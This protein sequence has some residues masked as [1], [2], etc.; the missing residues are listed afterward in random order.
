MNNKEIIDKYYAAANAGDWQTWLTL[1][2]DNVVV[3]EQ[4]AGHV[5]GI[6][7]LQGAIGGIERGYSKFINTPQH[8]VID[9]DT[10]CVVSHISAANASGVPIEA[11]VANYFE[12]KNG[13]ITYMANFHDTRPFDPFVNQ[14][15]D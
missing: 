2:D 10:A 13:K 14:T 15:F 3:D 6:A 4:L 12:I 9:G 1:F 11:N 7:V 8:I 5:E